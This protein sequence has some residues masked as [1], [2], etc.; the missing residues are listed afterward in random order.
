MTRGAPSV[1]KQQVGYRSQHDFFRVFLFRCDLLRELMLRLMLD[2]N[3]GA[4]SG[5]SQSVVP[6]P[7]MQTDT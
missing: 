4:T 5:S 1:A 6:A 7:E 2:V 3:D